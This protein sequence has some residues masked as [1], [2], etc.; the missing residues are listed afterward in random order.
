MTN[1]YIWFIV[2]FNYIEIV[3]ILLRHIGEKWLTLASSFTRLQEK[4]NIL[5]NNGGKGTQNCQVLNVYTLENI[6]KG[7]QNF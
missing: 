3:D 4:V 5:R 6:L 7:I 1:L 2:H